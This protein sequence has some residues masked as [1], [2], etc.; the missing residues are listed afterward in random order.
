MS[1]ACWMF[2]P[3]CTMRRKKISRPL[4]LLLPARRP[5]RH[6]RRFPSRSAKRRRSASCAAACPA[7]GCSAAPAAAR[8]SA[9][10]SPAESPAPG[11]TGEDC[12][13]P[14]DGVAADH[15]APAVD[16]VDMHGVGRRSRPSRAT[17]GS[18]APGCPRQHSPPATPRCGPPMAVS[19]GYR[20]RPAATPSTSPAPPPAPGAQS[21]V[22]GR[23]QRI[24]RHIHAIRI[25]VVRFPVRVGELHAL[26]R[27]CARTPAPSGS[28]APRSNP[29]QQRQLLQEHRP[30]RSTAPHFSTVCRPYW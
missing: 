1:I 5:E 30:L 28:I 18:P 29:C 22:R 24:D 19:P 13:H 25:A 23:Q 12:S 15:V 27:P 20:P 17:V 3:W 10:A 21:V 11:T 6:P 4:V 9:P 14:P 26:H 8:T 16:H 2:S 7:P